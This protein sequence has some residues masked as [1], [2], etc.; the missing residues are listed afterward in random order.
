MNPA[1]PVRSTLRGSYNSDGEAAG[2]G[3]DGEGGEDDGGEEQDSV[4]EHGEGAT[5]EEKP[6]EGVADAEADCI[7][8]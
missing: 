1:P 5:V 4:G 8:C 6:A 7:S 2:G 3:G